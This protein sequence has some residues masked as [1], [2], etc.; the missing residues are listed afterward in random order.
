MFEID[1]GFIG[2]FKLGDN[3]NFNL[4]QIEAL[5]IAMNST[6][7]G[8]HKR[9]LCKPV[10]VALIS[11]IEALLHDLH[12]KVRLYTREGV[13]NL[14]DQV[15]EYIRGKKQDK[16]AL[17]VVSAEKHKLL[18]DDPD[19]YKELDVLRQVRN[20][21]HIQNAPP[22]LDADEK[23]VFTPPMVKRSE[24]AL[25]KVMRYMAKNY[26]RP[27]HAQKHVAP[28]QLPWEPHFSENG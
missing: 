27:V 1:S 25:E 18:G 4:K 5:Y 11:I 19:L 6:T 9:A 22:Q 16:M 2:I 28:F 20:R 12:V 10:C 7:N 21:L 3:V 13:P 26:L 23:N 15:R 24:Q 14:P 17:L 8:V